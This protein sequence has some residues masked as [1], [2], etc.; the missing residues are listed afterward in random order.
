[1]RKLLTRPLFGAFGTLLLFSFGALGDTVNMKLVTTNAK[2]VMG[3]VYTSPYGVSID[4]GPTTLMICDDFLTNTSVGQTWSSQVTTLADLQ[5]GTNPVGTPKFANDLRD[6]ATAAVLAAQLMGLG[7]FSNATAG[8]LSYAIWG[9]FDPD[10]LTNNPASG[11]G[12]LTA[13][14]LAAAKTFLASAQAVV[15]AATVGGVIDL[16][17]IPS[18]TIYTPDPLGASQEFLRVS[19]TEPSFIAM[20]CVDLVGIVAFVLFLRRRTA[21]AN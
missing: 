15:D 12:H 8:E 21:R 2:Y 13:T 19:M 10:L 4:G 16:S 18:M 3:G 5:A 11:V 20:L 1:M 17:K 7:N 6:Y 9:V 14:Q